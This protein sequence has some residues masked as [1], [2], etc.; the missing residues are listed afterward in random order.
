MNKLK[1]VLVLVFK[2]MINGLGINLKRTR[3]N[4]TD[5]TQPT[6]P[7][8]CIS[9]PDEWKTWGPKC[10]F[11]CHCKNNTQCSSTGFCASGCERGW[12]RYSTKSPC[13]ELASNFLSRL[14]SPEQDRKHGSS[15]SFRNR[16]KNVD[17]GKNHTQLRQATRTAPVVL[18]YTFVSELRCLTG[19]EIN[20][21]TLTANSSTTISVSYVYVRLHSHYGNKRIPL[22]LRIYI[23]DYAK[24]GNYTFLL[25]SVLKQK[26]EMFFKHFKLPV[27]LNEIRLVLEL[28]EEVSCTDIHNTAMVVVY[29]LPICPYRRWGLNCEHRCRC[30]CELPE[31]HPVTGS[32]LSRPLFCPLGTYGRHCEKFCSPSCKH[33]IL[34]PSLENRTREFSNECHVVSGFCRVCPSLAQTGPECNDAVPEAEVGAILASCANVSNSDP[35]GGDDFDIH[36]LE[37]RLRHVIKA[38]QWWR[39]ESAFWVVL[40]CLILFLLMFC[41]YLLCVRL[42]ARQRLRGYRVQ[43]EHQRNMRT[44]I[45]SWAELKEEFR[46]MRKLSR[47]GHSV[48]QSVD[49]GPKD[50]P[51]RT[52]SFKVSD[53]SVDPSYPKDKYRSRSLMDSESFSTSTSIPGVARKVSFK[54]W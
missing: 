41:G 31:C 9:K 21:L 38:K 3:E 24:P 29:G 20:Q 49:S 26:D 32:C 28:D 39:R 45:K 54:V 37:Q 18:P 35:D 50:T 25:N 47:A 11:Q 17:S 27:L 52:N 30:P 2:M 33:P 4:N 48:S 15:A 42:F 34:N 23:N 36:N 13:L 16:H 40:S 1:I 46:A 22:K 12:G 43:L 8:S 51:N 44:S 5:L 10:R 19:K 6:P 53:S 14:W 7:S